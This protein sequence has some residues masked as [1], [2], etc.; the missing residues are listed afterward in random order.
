MVLRKLQSSNLEQRKVVSAGI[1]SALACW[2]APGREF[3][4][5]YFL[6]QEICCLVRS[7]ARKAACGYC[8]FC[9]LFAKTDME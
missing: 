2:Q 4:Q 7:G 1:R 9:T 8:P 5:H 3:W 6:G